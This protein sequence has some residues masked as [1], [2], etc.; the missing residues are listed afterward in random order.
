[1]TT[2][3]PMAMFLS[4]SRS[5]QVAGSVVTAQAI[6]NTILAASL[7]MSMISHGLLRIALPF[8]CSYLPPDRVGE[9]D[10]GASWECCGGSC[11]GLRAQGLRPAV[12]AIGSQQ[13]T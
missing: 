9:R 5:A 10:F 6:T 2:L 4:C 8:D 1:M 3:K 12:C 7:V 11:W 13:F